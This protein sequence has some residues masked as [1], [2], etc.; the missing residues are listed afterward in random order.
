LLSSESLEELGKRIGDVCVDLGHLVSDLV[1]GS[2]VIQVQCT[3][4]ITDGHGVPI[5][6]TVDGLLWTESG[7]ESS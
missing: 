4:P 3:V 2:V 1:L 6:G 5:F 7:V